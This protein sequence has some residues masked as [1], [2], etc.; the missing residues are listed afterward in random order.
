MAAAPQTAQRRKWSHGNAVRWNFGSVEGES[1]PRPWDRVEQMVPGRRS[2]NS[3]HF[4]PRRQGRKEEHSSCSWHGARG[5]EWSPRLLGTREGNAV[6]VLA[7]LACLARE[8]Q[9]L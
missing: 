8:L 7:V 6:T 9:R 1:P 3:E 2:H 4:T 5:K